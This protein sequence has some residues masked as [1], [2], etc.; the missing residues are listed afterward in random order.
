MKLN[1]INA[2]MSLSR[3]PM[4]KS[5]DISKDNNSTRSNMD[6]L[7][8]GE[9]DDKA[10]GETEQSIGIFQNAIYPTK[11][12]RYKRATDKEVPEKEKESTCF[13][14]YYIFTRWWFYVFVILPILAILI[15]FCILSPLCGAILATMVLLIVIAI[16]WGSSIHS[17]KTITG[18]GAKMND[19]FKPI[20][21]LIN[22]TINSQLRK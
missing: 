11:L 4:M 12:N 1:L 6:H 17:S 9:L 13:N 7:W 8:K 19:T 2:I 16:I 15:I 18:E 20:S 22:N 21:T 5:S 3:Y 14:W 10:F